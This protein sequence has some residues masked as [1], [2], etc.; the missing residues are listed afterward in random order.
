MLHEHGISTWGS[1]VFG[2][3]TDDPEVFDRTV[4]F[5]IDMRLT[6]ALFAILT[7]YPG[8][9]LYRRL[10]AERRLT[11]ERWWLL[12]NHDQGSPYF[13][14]TRMTRE[15]LHEGW[16]RAWQRFYSAR[17]ILR[18]WTVRRRSSWIQSLGYLPL[19]MMQQALAHHKIGG[20]NP[21]FRSADN[22][23]L[24]HLRDDDLASVAELEAAID[25]AA[26]KSNL[27]PSD[28]RRALPMA[29]V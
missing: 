21:R 4:E 13:V 6:M 19:N 12:P 14:P 5:G 18:R 8:T 1:F 29:G 17:S 15:Q 25:A 2:F 11:H 28:R 16:V 20:K 3:D 7:P 27:E 22:H 24:A 9:R 10:L 23:A 26:S